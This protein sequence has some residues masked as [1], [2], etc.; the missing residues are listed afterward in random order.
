MTVPYRFEQFL[1][2]RMSV[3]RGGHEPVELHDRRSRANIEAREPSATKFGV[4]R[5]CG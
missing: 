5:V 2:G 3:P 1:R 4:D